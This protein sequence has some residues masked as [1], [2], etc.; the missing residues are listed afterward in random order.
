MNWT[1]AYIWRVGTGSYNGKL[2]ISKAIPPPPK[3]E[4]ADA[5]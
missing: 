5:D 3:D 2:F 1:D 4:R